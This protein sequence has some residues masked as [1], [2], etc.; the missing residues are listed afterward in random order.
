[1]IVLELRLFGT[2][3]ARLFDRPLAGFPSRQAYCLL[4]YLLLNRGHPQH[5]ERLAALFWGDHSQERARSC[6]N[7]ALWRLRQVL[8]PDAAQRGTYLLTTGAGEVG[9]NLGSDYWLDV[10]AFEGACD[11]V[12]VR[13]VEAVGAA[14]VEILEKAIALYSGDL[15]EGLYEDWALRERERLRRLYLNSLARLMQYHKHHQ[16][17]EAALACGRRILDRDPLREEI[18]RDIMRLYLADG[19]R[20][21]AVRQ[22]QLCCEVLEGELG[23]PP[24]E[25]TQAL[26]T[27]ILGGAEPHST[28]AVGAPESDGQAEVV[29]QLRLAMQNFDEARAQLDRA[30]QLVERYAGDQA[31]P[32]AEG[33]DGV[34]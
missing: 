3:Q 11:Q 19:Q 20:A 8:E 33:S 21:R 29:E 23:I 1:V 18:H 34:T 32:D 31:E 26:Y 16:A 25:E 28:P 24:M 27:Q 15:L 14:D 9:F 30:I 6:L 5:R 2:G 7:T 4:C 12:L 22:Y 17:F 10:A 13:P